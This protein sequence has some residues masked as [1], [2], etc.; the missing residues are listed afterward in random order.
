MTELGKLLQASYVVV[1][2][3]NN[4][5]Q[6]GFKVLRHSRDSRFATTGTVPPVSTVDVNGIMEYYNDQGDEVAYSGRVLRWSKDEVPQA[7]ME[8]SAR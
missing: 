2:Y 3:W 1:S 7:Q 5:E 8:G 4:Q 6:I